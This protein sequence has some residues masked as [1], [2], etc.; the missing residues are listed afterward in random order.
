MV[1]LLHLGMFG[2]ESATGRLSKRFLAT[3]GGKQGCILAPLLFIIYYAA[4]LRQAFSNTKDG[5]F[6]CFWTSG[7]LFNLR[8]LQVTTRLM[9]ELIH[10]L[11]HADDCTLFTHTESELQEKTNHFARASAASGLTINV[12]KRGLASM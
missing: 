11:L 5:I 7:R 4:M 10:V 1:K 2:V 3:N 12:G 9:E 8:Q 6:I